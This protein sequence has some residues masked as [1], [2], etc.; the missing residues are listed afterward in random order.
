MTSTRGFL[1]NGVIL[2]QLLHAWDAIQRF[3]G[4]HPDR[5]SVGQDS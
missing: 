5:L 1:L 3:F 2:Q 4:V